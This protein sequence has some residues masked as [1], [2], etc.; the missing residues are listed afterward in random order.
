MTSL[1][2]ATESEAALYEE[3]KM[4]DQLMETVR[5]KKTLRVYYESSHKLDALLDQYEALAELAENMIEVVIAKKNELD[6][7]KYQLEE[8]A[9]ENQSI[10]APIDVSSTFLGYAIRADVSWSTLIE[11]AELEKDAIEK[12]NG[13]WQQFSDRGERSNKGRKGKSNQPPQ[14]V[15]T[16]ALSRYDG[17]DLGFIANFPV[18]R[19][20]SHI[21]A[22]IYYYYGDA[23]HKEGLYISPSPGF[24]TRIPMPAADGA[25]ASTKCCLSRSVEKCEKKNE[26]ANKYI[27]NAKNKKECQLMHFDE[28]YR[29]ITNPLRC[30]KMPMF[31]APETLKD[32][33]VNIDDLDIRT[34][35]TFAFNDFFLMALW[36]KRKSIDDG[37]VIV[38][39]DLDVCKP[40][41]L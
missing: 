19:S 8:N 10:D 6:A 3:F 24:Y 7:I 17:V 13:R 26:L 4:V 25:K 23:K 28:K 1:G 20:L 29:R 32:D 9:E 22:A 36:Y 5:A 38:V 40:S 27:K 16:K 14:P 12:V 2:K 21:P 37:V 31:G 30:D 39:D 41:L 35:G 34:V 11:E 15:D 18:V 33:L